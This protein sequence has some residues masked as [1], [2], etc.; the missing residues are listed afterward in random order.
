[1][2]HTTSRKPASNADQLLEELGRPSPQ[3]MSMEDIAWACGLIVRKAPM[4]GCEGRIIMDDHSGIIT[5]NESIDY[6]PKIN[7]IIAHE[8][9]HS[10]LHRG[11]RFF[12]DT[13]KTLQ[14]WYA[15]GAHEYEANCFA[16]ELLMPTVPFKKL[17]LKKNLSLQLVEQLSAYF[18]ASKTAIYL[19]YR[20]L[21]EF[22]VM[23]VFI[24]NGHIKWKTESADFPFKW[25]PYGS[26]V[27]P[28]S[29]AGDYFHNGVTESRPVKVAASE[30]FPDNYGVQR[31]EDRQLWEQCFPATRTSILTCLW[32]P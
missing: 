8:I 26:P 12:A 1:M 21:G 18:G 2:I 32:T 15:R 4:D 3:D 23:I 30:W 27:P 25:L 24:E 10:R 6:Q 5:I 13:N 11:L 31:G 22:P 16:A 7:Y 14:E 29:V 28:L 20:D 9:G 19:R 17:V